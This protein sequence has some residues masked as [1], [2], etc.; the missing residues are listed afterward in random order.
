MGFVCFLALQQ[1]HEHVFYDFKTLIDTN[2]DVLEK[3]IPPKY[4][5]ILL[6][7]LLIIFT[8]KI[9]LM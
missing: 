9:E 7:L 1:I 4:G 2:Q 6:F 5:E 3:E 8:I